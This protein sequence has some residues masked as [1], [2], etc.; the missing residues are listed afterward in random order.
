MEFDRV[1]GLLSEVRCNGR[2]ALLQPT[3]RDHLDLRSLA[4]RRRDERGGAHEKR[5]AERVAHMDLPSA[6][7][8]PPLWRDYVWGE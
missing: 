3:D 1:A 8:F 4:E 2:D 6:A 5:S 7:C